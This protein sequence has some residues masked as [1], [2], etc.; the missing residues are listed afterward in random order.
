[1]NRQA[2]LIEL[3]NSKF[4]NPHGLPNQE[5]RSTATDIARLC[6]ICMKKNLFK[7]IVGCQK[8]KTLAQYEKGTR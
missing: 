5:A 2:K 4:A 8:Y 3:K 6:C 7:T 1:M